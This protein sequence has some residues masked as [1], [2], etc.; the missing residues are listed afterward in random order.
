MVPTIAYCAA[1]AQPLPATRR[2]RAGIAR[3]TT[4]TTIFRGFPEG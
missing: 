2:T 1:R 4:V 3:M